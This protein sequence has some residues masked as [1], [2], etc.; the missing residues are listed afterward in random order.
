VQ[1][2]TPYYLLMQKTTT[3]SYKSIEREEGRE[4]SPA[5]L[6]KKR[7]GEELT[8]HCTGP[9]S[10]GLSSSTTTMRPR[11]RMAS[12]SSSGTAAGGPCGTR[13]SSSSSGTVTMGPY[14]SETA[15][16]PMHMHFTSSVCAT[17]NSSLF[18]S[19]VICKNH[20][21]PKCYNK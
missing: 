18:L 4:E 20:N 1:S 8:K 15:S 12:P 3:T 11:V 7:K 21:I 17:P 10:S 16:S 13:T 9:S 2:C 6:R 14:N 19:N 5:F